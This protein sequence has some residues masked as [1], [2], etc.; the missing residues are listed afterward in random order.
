MCF[1]CIFDM[2]GR[3]PFCISS[4]CHMP[5]CPSYQF[6]TFQVNC[7]KCHS[8]IEH[9]RTLNTVEFDSSTKRTLAPGNTL[10]AI[11]KIQSFPLFTFLNGEKCSHGLYLIKLGKMLGL[12]KD[13][14]YQILFY[15]YF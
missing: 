7:F 8:K 14:L 6:P 12:V 10:S 1:L 2:P 11:L 15:V 4:N 13:I 3:G 5:R 9:R